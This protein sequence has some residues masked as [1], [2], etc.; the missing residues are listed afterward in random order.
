MTHRPTLEGVLG[1]G[2]WAHRRRTAQRRTRRRSATVGSDEY[3]GVKKALSLRDPAL[4]Q[5]PGLDERFESALACLRRRHDVPP[6]A[7]RAATRWRSA[8]E[9]GDEHVGVKRRDPFERQLANT[10]SERRDQGAHA[11]R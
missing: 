1:S 4:W 8:T 3:A 10:R 9:G 6:I 7:E 2:T 5:P 11:R